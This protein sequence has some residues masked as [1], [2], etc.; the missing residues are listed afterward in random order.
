MSPLPIEQL[1]TFTLPFFYCGVD[2]FGPILIKFTKH[3]RA[4]S[5]N[6]KRYEAL[7]TCM[8]TRS[9]H[10]ELA[11]EISTDSFI[12]GL[13]RSIRRRGHPKQIRSDNGTIFVGVERKIKEALRQL[14]Q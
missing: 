10:L 9:I 1:S 8:S 4:V 3:N 14:Q 7:F 11:G 13:R 5:G 12:Q 2:Y 6:A